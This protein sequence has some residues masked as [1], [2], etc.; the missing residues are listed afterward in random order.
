LTAPT[1]ATRLPAMRCAILCRKSNP[2]E[3]TGDEKSVA[4]Q[5]RECRALIERNGWELADGHLY[6]EDVVS[7]VLMTP[8]GRPEL[9]RLLAACESK[10]RRPFDVVVVSHEDRFGRDMYRTGIIVKQ[11]IE[12]GV[13]VFS[14]ASGERKLDTA[15]DD[16]LM[17]ISGF[18]AQLER[19][20]TSRRVRAK[21]FD[22]ARRGHATGLR[23]FGYDSVDVN[24]HKELQVN[25]AEAEI[26]RWIF[27]LCQ[28]GY[29][30]R[31]IAH[32]LNEQ[33]GG[34]H[35]W[36][37]TGVRD[38]LKNEIYIGQVVYGRTR[39]EVR[40]GV[41]RKVAV[42]EAEWVRIERPELRIVPQPLW[43]AAQAR[44]AATFAAYPQTAEGHLS[45][46]PSRSALASKYLLAG[47]LRCG[48]CGGKLISLRRGKRPGGKRHLYYA[49]WT[50]RGRGATVCTNRR[51]VPMGRLHDM[52]V[53][54][55]QQDILTPA[56]LER[57]IR[58]LA[59][60]HEQGPARAAEVRR[61]LEADL[62]RVEGRIANLT[63]AV[64]AGG[65]VKSLIAAIRTAEREQQ[66]IRDRL[67]HAEGLQKAG[68]AWDESAYRE[69][70]LALLDDWQGALKAAPQIARQ[71]LRKLLVT[72]ITVTPGENAA[73]RWFKYEAQGTFRRIWSGTMGPG[74]M[75]SRWVKEMPYLA[76]YPFGSTTLASK[77]MIPADL[78]EAELTELV[79]AQERKTD[80]SLGSGSVLSVTGAPGPRSSRRPP[81]SRAG[82]RGTESRS[83]SRP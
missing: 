40:K 1:M 38:I 50:S 82:W 56:R 15:T 64:A 23:A 51:V 2:Q 76:A 19:E 53:T 79:R 66:N 14:V 55:F 72:D 26:V 70:V 24:G 22:N 75:E 37:H 46:P 13:K 33:H 39:N 28:Q 16:L 10:G 6:V 81:G 71:I 67:E 69:R 83:R 12:A 54:M 3:A 60:G 29:G 52:V 41:K 68:A 78:V 63:E 61:A 34:L 5:E 49:C 8:E 73:G 74:G 45:G 11:I 9:F 18:G 59:R 36:S 57:V 58:D 77:D 4:V 42:P 47:M 80:L 30:I 43:D 32:R 31:R 21:A 35:R 25:A 44:K 65:E 7:G 62:H 20:S 27:D 17:A 48:V